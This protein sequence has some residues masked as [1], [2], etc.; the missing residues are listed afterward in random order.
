MQTAGVVL[1][2]SDYLSNCYT[3]ASTVVVLGIGDGEILRQIAADPRLNLKDIRAVALPGES[4]PDGL[5]LPTA[6]V[7]RISTWPEAEA[8]I[9]ARFGSHEDIIRLSGTDFITSHPL[10]P[11]ASAFR[12][13]ILPRF[14]QSL[15]DRPWSLGNDINDT[16]MGLYHSALN[17]KALL[18]M[19][20]L[21]D[22]SGSFSCPAIS[23]GAGPSVKDHCEELRQ[24]QDRCILVACD[25]VYPALIKEGIIP[26]FVCPLERLKQQAP[27]LVSA[28]NTRTIFA[29]I[30]AC[31]PDT[32]AHFA[33]RTVYVHA[34]DR[35]YDWL[36]PSERLRCCTGSS[37]GVLSFLVAA[38]LTRGPV[39]L[40]GHDL[41][42]DEHGKTHFE[43]CDLAAKAF[44]TESKA[45]GAFG[46]NGYE[47]RWIPG[48]NNQL[49]ESIAWWD[50]FRLE[51]SS[52]AK[53]IPGRVFNVN[54]ADHRFALIE[55]T[56]AQA[57]PDPATLQPLPPIRYEPTNH[58][59]YTDWSSRARLLPADCRHFIAALDLYRNDIRGAYQ[60]HPTSPESWGC[61]AMMKRM[62]PDMG[63]SAGNAAAFQY[64]LRSAITN[65]Q[66]FMSHRVRSLKT[67]EQCFFHTMRS[68][69]GLADAMKIAVETVQ[70]CL[71]EIANAC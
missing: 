8:W 50:T 70:P 65:E 53:L 12:T 66:M 14:T 46:T 59:R 39:Y 57:L 52:Q 4:L 38:S 15:A 22:I 6:L 29:G 9:F 69:D 44:K 45:S 42:K 47:S 58:L 37:T 62:T 10:G 64:F 33:D 43:S 27:L 55:H 67:R 49:V 17:A 68:L 60:S 24:L 11:A 19:P 7:D 40:V 26:H 31:H 34:M 18:P 3:P 56:Q 30:S 54:G 51:I 5:N 35:L 21:G 16:F 36:A 20:S 28:E 2:A 48:N 61:E 32:V 13:E 23:I 63:V 25:A 1:E 41:A 71:E